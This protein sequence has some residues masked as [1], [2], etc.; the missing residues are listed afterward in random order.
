VSQ[1]HA[2]EYSNAKFNAVGSENTCWSVVHVRS[3]INSL[4]AEFFENIF[5][6]VINFSIHTEVR[7]QEV[8]P[9]ENVFLWHWWVGDLIFMEIFQAF[10]DSVD[11][12]SFVVDFMG[13]LLLGC[14][15]V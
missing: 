7:S 15:C 2:S 3:E 5:D 4:I 9:W 13:L 1:S 6:F 14:S 12:I 8:L 11:F 10:N